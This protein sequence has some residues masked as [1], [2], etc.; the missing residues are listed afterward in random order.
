MTVIKKG[1][2]WWLIT[3]IFFEAVLYILMFMNSFRNS[4][5]ALERHFINDI[6]NNSKRNGIIFVRDELR[7]DMEK[8]EI[9][10][11]K[12]DS[13]S[14]SNFFGACGY[15][16]F[17]ALRSNGMTTDPIIAAADDIACNPADAKYNG[18]DL[19]SFQHIHLQTKY[20]SAHGCI[21][22]NFGLPEERSVCALLRG[23][24]T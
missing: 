7:P 6:A 2:M 3:L 9:Q 5:F 8:S 14:C 21:S 13:R 17:T 4:H 11:S 12:M 1:S 19:A 10:S 16:N 15:P 22:V 23:C 20:I 18:V 24:L